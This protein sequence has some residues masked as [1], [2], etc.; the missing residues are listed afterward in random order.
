EV[1]KTVQNNYNTVLENLLTKEEQQQFYKVVKE[2]ELI[3]NTASSVLKVSKKNE[4]KEI[5][6]CLKAEIESINGKDDNTIDLNNVELTKEDMKTVVEVAKVKSKELNIKAENII[7][8]LNIILLTDLKKQ[9]VKES[10][11]FSEV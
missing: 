10:R 2:D 1:M 8:G 6:R 9:S 11:E 5:E 4:I 3:V 7:K